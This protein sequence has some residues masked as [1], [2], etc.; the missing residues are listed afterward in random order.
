M[1]EQGMGER[2]V[3]EVGEASG[4]VGAAGGLGPVALSPRQRDELVELVNARQAREDWGGRRY[5]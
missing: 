3:S 5:G 2:R 4:E 1:S